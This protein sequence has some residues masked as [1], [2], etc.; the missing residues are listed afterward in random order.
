LEGL[1]DSA[2]ETLQIAASQKRFTSKDEI[3]TRG[4]ISQTAID[5]LSE[6]GVIHGLPQSAQLSIFDVLD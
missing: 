3:K 1:G 6:L 5:K 4:K 2:A